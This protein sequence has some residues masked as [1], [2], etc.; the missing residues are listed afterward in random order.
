MGETLHKRGSK[1]YYEEKLNE[2]YCSTVKN[3]LSEIANSSKNLPL[4]LIV[5]PWLC[6][7]SSLDK[8]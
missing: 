2:I 7:F 3:K 6:V 4:G 8:I 1:K 5:N